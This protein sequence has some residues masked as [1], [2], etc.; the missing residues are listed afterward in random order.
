ME[1]A[2]QRFLAELEVLEPVSA[3]GFQVF[4]L[5]RSGDSR[6][7]YLTLD[8]ALQKDLV[9]VTEV[10][11]GGSVPNLKVSNK[12]EDL[13]FLMAGEQ[14]KG[15]KQ[16]RVLNVDIMVG[17]RS[18]TAIPVSCVEAGRWSYSS[19][20][21]MSAE[22]LSHSLLRAKM[23]RDVKESYARMGSPMSKQGEVWEEVTR[24]LHRMASV[25][26]SA[27]LNQVY[28]DY[29]A[30]LKKLTEEL[31]APAGSSGAVFVIGG[32][33]AGMDLFDKSATFEKLWP[34]L[35]KSYAIDALE[36]PGESA[37]QTRESVSI[38]LKNALEVKSE[39]FRSP[40]LGDDV[41]LEGENLVGSSLLVE[42]EPV[43][44]ELFSASKR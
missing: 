29:G 20:K 12:A 8:E 34:K 43:H 38:W 44:T 5:R 42:D 37:P 27:A 16:N 28:E 22:S 21:F 40:G 19:P 41:R 36:E 18:E 35:I 23:S 1:T 13:L 31:K 15:A 7:S 10:S 3:N 39:K 30:K 24:K 9:D 4:G 33:I 25:S 2:I 17:S 11:E 14:L 6:V 32:R 26:P